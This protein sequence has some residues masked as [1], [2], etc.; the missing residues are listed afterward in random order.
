MYGHNYAS[1]GTYEVTIVVAGRQPVFG[2]IAG[3]TRAGGEAPH[4][5]PSALGLAVLRD[6]IP[7]IHR[8][9]PMVD[10]W[11]VCL[12]PDHLHM[13]VRINGQLPEGK[14]LG[15]II[16]AFKG[17]ISRAWW[18]LTEGTEADASDTGARGERASNT[19][20]PGST[21]APVSGASAPDS[22]PPLFEPNYN[23]HILMRDGQLENWKRYLRDNP[24]RLMMRREYPDLFRRAICIVID[25]IRYSAF[26]NL[27]LLRQ[28]EKHQVFFHR[29]TGGVPTE[30]TDF[31]IT[32]CERL[33]SAAMSGDVLVTPGISECEKRIKN[34]ALAQGL[35]LIHV[36]SEPIG[37]YWKPEC[38]RFEACAAGALLILAPWPEDMPSFE[39]DYGRFHYL[40]RLAGAVCAIGHSTSVAVK[41]VCQG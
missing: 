3:T 12:M 38:S 23:D 34:M 25:G 21:N 24:S 10:I 9:Y 16:G 19:P 6:E 39:S 22:R 26:G 32:E 35:R 33:I 31:W 2:E 8:Y 4:I 17:G 41:G 27:L 29:R 28:P 7:K 13:I 14:H 40:N 20:A 36:Q 18:R 15:I 37:R 1:Y 30:Q 11:Q 5:K